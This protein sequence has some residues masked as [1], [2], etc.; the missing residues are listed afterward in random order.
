MSL[1][2]KNI[3]TEKMPKHITQKEALAMKDRIAEMEQSINVFFDKYNEIRGSLYGILES[4]IDL[5]Q[6]MTS[7]LEKNLMLSDTSIKKQIELK[8]PEF[9]I[10]RD[11]YMKQVGKAELLKTLLGKLQKLIP[12]KKQE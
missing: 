5:A 11:E 12:E 4:E 3:K 2:T 9:C 10:V 8:H 1:E 7:N 6:T